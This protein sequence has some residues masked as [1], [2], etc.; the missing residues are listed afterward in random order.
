M[1]KPINNA[2]SFS[3]GN[4]NY[5]ITF[6]KD[7]FIIPVNL[8]TAESKIKVTVYESGKTSVYDDCEVSKVNREGSTID[9]FEAVISS[10]K[11]KKHEWKADSKITIEITYGDA[12]DK[13]VQIKYAVS[14]YEKG[15]L[16]LGYT[17]EFKAQ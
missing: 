8:L 6:D 9:T 13:T 3:G 16:G 5:A 12:Y 4:T 10:K 2:Y 14:K 7:D 17:V 15:F 1:T 11:L